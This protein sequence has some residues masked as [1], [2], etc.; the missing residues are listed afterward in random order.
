MAAARVGWSV[1]AEPVRRRGD[2]LGFGLAV[3]LFLPGVAYLGITN[4]RDFIENGFFAFMYCL[5]SV[6]FASAPL[7]AWRRNGSWYADPSF[8]RT[9]WFPWL[10]T[11]MQ[12]VAYSI[13]RT[14]S[15]IFLLVLGWGGFISAGFVAMYYLG[16]DFW[17]NAQELAAHNTAKPRNVIVSRIRLARTLSPGRPGANSSAEDDAGAWQSV[18]RPLPVGLVFGPTR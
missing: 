7:L 13:Q 14:D 18:S 1:T 15:N 11:T 10:F 16:N 8:G 4:G 6:G 5:A 17:L 12:G 2:V 9:T 3:V